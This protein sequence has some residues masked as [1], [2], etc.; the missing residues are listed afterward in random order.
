MTNKEIHAAS[1]LMHKSLKAANAINPESTPKDIQQALYN[2][3]KEV[4]QPIIDN[5]NK[6]NVFEL[7]ERLLTDSK[8][9]RVW[10]ISQLAKQ[11]N[12]NNASAAKELASQLGMTGIEQDLSIELVGYDGLCDQCQHT[13]ALS[14]DAP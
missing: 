9:A 10:M 12:G 8:Y 3:I 6:K 1:N 7:A 5:N 4:N 2:A 13:F 11:M 14:N